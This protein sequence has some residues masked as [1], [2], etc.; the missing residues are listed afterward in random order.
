MIQAV[1]KVGGSLSRGEHLPAL[2]KHLG[3][4][5]RRYR[6]LVV[7]GGGP[8]ADV[9]RT[10][11]RQFGLGDSAAHWMAILGMDQY[12]WLLADLVPESEPVWTLAAAHIA[13]QAGRVPVL[14][15]WALLYAMDP[16]PHTWD[17]T[18]DSIAAWVAGMV[19][20]PLL[21]LLKDVDGIFDE[22]PREA[23]HRCLH[24]RI[25]VEQLGRFG[26][27]D[28]HL[29]ALVAQ[30]GLDL[31]LVNGEQPGRLEELL[32]TGA[33]VGTRALSKGEVAQGN[34]PVPG[35]ATEPKG[36]DPAG[37]TGAQ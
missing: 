31:W 20:A 6:L 28:G 36:L 27:V 29:P 8:F 2:G 30:Y 3:E 9:V 13:S 34:S 19:Q 1:V 10:Q 37:S 16:L 26:V 4:V 32:S 5:G 18:S 25:A 22:R 21:V 35:T 24:E 7:P 33:T 15:P 14:L 23:S 11:D 17:V 12:G